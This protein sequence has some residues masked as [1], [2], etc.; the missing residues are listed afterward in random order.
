MVENKNKFQKTYLMYCGLFFAYLI[1][2]LKFINDSW[3]GTDELDI[4]IYGKGIAHGQLLYVDVVSQHMPFSYYISAIFC[5]LGANTVTQQRF[6]FYVMFACL[7]TVIVY[8][9]SHY[10]NKIVLILYPFVHCC[11]IQNYLMG[12]AILSEHIAGCGAVILL[13]EFMVFVQKRDFN[14]WNHIM[15]SLAIVLMFGTIFVAIFPIFFIAVGVLV[16]ELKWKKERSINNKKFIFDFIKRYYKL[17]VIA[18]VPWGGLFIYYLI[19]GTMQEFIYGAYTF[20][21]DVYS[22]YNGGFGNN[23]L[24]SFLSPA[25]TWGSLIYN[26]FNFSQWGYFDVLKWI[27]VIC[28]CIFIYKCVLKDG[29]IVAATIA[30]YIYSLGIRGNFH[31]HGTAFEEVSAFVVVYVCYYYFYKNKKHFKSI[32]IIKQSILVMIIA[33]ISSGYCNNFSK[34]AS[35]SYNEEQTQASTIIGKIT[36]ENESIW[37]SVFATSDIMLAERLAVGAASTTPWTWEGFG[38][39]QFNE[40]KKASPRV[41][42]YSPTFECCGHKIQDYAPELGEYFEGSYTL[43]PDTDSLYVR[44][45]YYDEACKKIGIQPLTEKKN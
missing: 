7:W 40:L 31:F 20:N 38:E 1:I 19:K 37:M 35:I 12:T 17:G 13:L 22:K 33:I 10:I 5:K 36:D 44:N 32:G 4:M 24:S 42:I 28:S 6:A 41:A 43:L 39:K 9:Y 23:I 30:L 34:I 11:M 18:F 15:I 27:F 2:Q 16:L 45:D 29:W 26:A 14:F 21:R 8:R 3:F 25:D